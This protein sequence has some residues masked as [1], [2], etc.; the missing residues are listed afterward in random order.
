MD[1]YNTG[2]PIQTQ[3]KKDS[4]FI[5]HPNYRNCQMMT[6]LEYYGRQTGR[7]MNLNK[8]GNPAGGM[9]NL[10]SIHKLSIMEENKAGSLCP[11]FCRT[12][13]AKYSIVSS[14]SGR[15]IYYANEEQGCF[16]YCTR[17]LCGENR[18]TNIFINDNDN[19]PTMI[20][21][22]NFTGSFFCRL[23]GICLNRIEIYS[24]DR[25]A[26]TNSRRRLKKQSSSAQQNP[27]DIT[28]AKDR[29][30]I[31]SVDQHYNILFPRF[32]IRNQNN[33][34]FTLRRNGKTGPFFKQNMI[35]GRNQYLEDTEEK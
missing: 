28:S 24:I 12:A 20:A 18:F 13:K 30:L 15:V 17:T 7:S 14:E 31:G 1:H 26:I 11:S 5:H 27:M 29:I 19:F 35:F 4:L 16:S 6:E 23:F 3:P 32:I 10:I 25:K 34:P 9:D 21:R 33:R 2:K 8:D 22:K